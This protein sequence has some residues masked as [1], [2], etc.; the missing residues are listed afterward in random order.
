MAFSELDLKRI[1]STVGALCRRRCPAQYRS[2][3]RL[4]YA[5]KGQSVVIFETRPQWDDTTAPWTVHELAKLTFARTSGDWR[6]YWLRATLKWN[7][8]EPMPSA[9][10]L[11]D[12]VAEIDR[13]PH[14]CF[15]G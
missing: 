15:F 3:V 7:G 8:Y 10:S 4:E 12:L 13:D 14:A 9:R 5:V 6:L 1:D 2:K 11:A